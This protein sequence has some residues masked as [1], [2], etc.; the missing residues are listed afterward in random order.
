MI[1]LFLN[2]QYDSSISL[3]EANQTQRREGWRLLRKYSFFLEFVSYSQAA[4]CWLF[5]LIFSSGWSKLIWFEQE[6]FSLIEKSNYDKNASRLFFKWKIL[7]PLVL[8]TMFQSPWE[9]AADNLGSVSKQAKWNPRGES[10][11][12]H[13]ICLKIRKSVQ[14]NICSCE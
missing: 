9:D 5:L 2:Q 7:I 8:C 14:E 12:L 6:W 4:K 11:S 10:L 13:L 1:Q 3:A